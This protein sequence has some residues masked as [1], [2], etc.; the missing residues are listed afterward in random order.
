MGTLMKV[1]CNVSILLYYNLNLIYLFSQAPTAPDL[2]FDLLMSL[3]KKFDQDAIERD[4]SGKLMPSSV[5]DGVFIEE[6][7]SVTEADLTPLLVLPYQDMY[8]ILVAALETDAV[9]EH[10]SIFLYPS[11]SAHR[12]NGLFCRF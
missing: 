9:L 8:A 7:D 1:S 6:Y 2:V 4:S 3:F 12:A 10:V 11:P 5:L